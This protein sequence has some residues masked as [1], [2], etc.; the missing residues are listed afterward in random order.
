MNCPDCGFEI[1]DGLCLCPESIAYDLDEEGDFEPPE[2][3]NDYLE[4]YWL[5]YDEEEYD[6]YREG[7]W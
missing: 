5:Y 4:G 1:I 3:D 6:D 2:P 7:S